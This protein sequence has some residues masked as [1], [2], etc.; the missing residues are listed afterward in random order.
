MQFVAVVLGFLFLAA[1]PCEAMSLPPKLV[2]DEGPDAEY[3]LLDDAGFPVPGEEYGWLWSERSR[4]Q[5]KVFWGDSE[6]VLDHGAGTCMSGVMPG[7]Q[8]PVILAGHALSFF[9]PLQFFQEGDLL[10]LDTWYGQYDYEITDI[11][12]YDQFDL[13]RVIDQKIGR[14]IVWMTREDAKRAAA[15]EEMDTD[16]QEE[17]I[18]YT[19]YPFYPLA[20]EKTERYT[21]IA[22]KVAG[23]SVIWVDEGPQIVYSETN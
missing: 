8:G 10:H 2:T 5:V 13:Q 17:L 15:S 4:M 11:E 14:Q 6:E 22:R 12:V 3:L 7:S 9:Y 19:C 18:L 16:R 21:L 20:E 1:L 23:P